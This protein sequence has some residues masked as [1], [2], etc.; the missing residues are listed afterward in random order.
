MWAVSGSIRR[1]RGA[2]APKKAN[3]A[4]ARCSSS[5]N[6]HAPKLAAAVPART[7]KRGTPPPAAA[8]G[9]DA[10]DETAGLAPAGGAPGETP[11][12]LFAAFF[13]V[14][15]PLLDVFLPRARVKDT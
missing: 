11:A 12:A 6:C 14:K 8:S 1:M 3:C 13:W 10:G 2:A 15:W 9:A 4:R 5:R 7:A